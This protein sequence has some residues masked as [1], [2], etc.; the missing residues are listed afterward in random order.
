MA[1]SVGGVLVTES[2]RSPE[3]ARV[4]EVFKALRREA[5]LT[6]EDAADRVKLTLAGYRPYE[7][8]RRRLRTEQIALFADAF[9]ISVDALTERLGLKSPSPQDR[10]Y[11]AD[12]EQ[13][14]AELEGE[15]PEIAASVIRMLRESL[16]IARM[17]RLARE[18]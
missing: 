8:G 5:H 4:A 15:S 3:G 6:Q 2:R 11:S 16:S 14:M 18:N 9:G 10:R 7:Q 12:C 1:V 17:A 13:L